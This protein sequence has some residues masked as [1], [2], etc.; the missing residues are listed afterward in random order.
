[1]FWPKDKKRYENLKSSFTNLKLL[2]ED[3]YKSSFNG[4]L[5]VRFEGQVYYILIEQDYPERI[6][7]KDNEGKFLFNEGLTADEI[8]DKSLTNQASIDVYELDPE[9]IDMLVG[10]L[11]AVPLYANLSS[12]F[13]DF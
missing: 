3:L 8:Y 6:Y 5:E 9:K 4:F 7:I 2:I 12:E 13:T 11:N 1:M 10:Y